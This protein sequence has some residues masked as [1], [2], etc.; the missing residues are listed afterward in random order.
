[1]KYIERITWHF[2]WILKFSSK[3]DSPKRKPQK[4]QRSR[5]HINVFKNFGL[6]IHDYSKIIFFRY[7]TDK[8]FQILLLNL[9]RRIGITEVIFFWL[10]TYLRSQRYYAKFLDTKSSVRKVMILYFDTYVFPWDV[11]SDVRKMWANC[12]LGTF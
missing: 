12:S 1:M 10:K 7:Y 2:L 9:K 11:P 6:K 3:P 8:P 5:S 4:L